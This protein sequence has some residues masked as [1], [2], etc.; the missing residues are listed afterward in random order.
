MSTA[1]NF[2]DAQEND[3]KDWS[4]RPERTDSSAPTRAH[5]L[6]KVGLSQTQK[7]NRDNEHRQ[8]V[9]GI[10]ANDSVTSKV[11]KSFDR[12][13]TSMRANRN[14]G[15]LGQVGVWTRWVQWAAGSRWDA[16]T[17][18]ATN[19]MVLQVGDSFN[20]LPHQFKDARI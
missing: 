13:A 18:D 4:H 12:F 15:F 19:Q 17:Q 20:S 1:R 6:K 9:N 10:N 14:C 3:F 11:T 2:F 16:E 7:T 8:Q 5:R